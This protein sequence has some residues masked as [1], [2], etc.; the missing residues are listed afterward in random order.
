MYHNEKPMTKH[1]IEKIIKNTK[2]GE[3]V[4]LHI[5]DCDMK[6]GIQFSP[7]CNKCKIVL[8]ATIAIRLEARIFKGMS[9]NNVQYT[10]FST[11]EDRSYAKTKSISDAF[12]DGDNNTTLEFEKLNRDLSYSLKAKTEKEEVYIFE[13]MPYKKLV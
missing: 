6:R 2:Y 13:N 5:K 1:E 8:H 4:I 10:L 9:N 7:N 11:D 3:E 12:V